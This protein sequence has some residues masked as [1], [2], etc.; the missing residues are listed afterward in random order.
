MSL[1]VHQ[2]LPCRLRGTSN[3]NATP[4][5]LKRHSANLSAATHGKGDKQPNAA[6]GNRIA[7][8]EPKQGSKKRKDAEVPDAEW[9]EG[10]AVGKCSACGVP[11]HRLKFKG[12]LHEMRLTL[13]RVKPTTHY[14]QGET[15]YRTILSNITWKQPCSQLPTLYLRQQ[16]CSVI[17]DSNLS[18]H[19][20]QHIVIK[21]LDSGSYPTASNNVT[22]LLVV[23][24]SVHFLRQNAA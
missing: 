24:T 22:V 20:F 2:W 15:G 18:G 5:L 17:H 11:E 6:A 8:N 1:L 13:K 3:T 16:T 14:P 12:N 10:I 23:Y 21:K 9:Q 4:L 7:S 19:C